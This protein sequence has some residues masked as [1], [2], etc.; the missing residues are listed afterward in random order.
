MIDPL[1]GTVLHTVQAQTEREWEIIPD[2]PEFQFEVPDLRAIAEMFGE[3]GMKPRFADLHD[4]P[5]AIHTDSCDSRRAR[6][7]A[8][9]ASSLSA[10]AKYW[11]LRMR[12]PD[13]DTRGLRRNPGGEI[14]DPLARKKF[15]AMVDSFYRSPSL[16]SLSAGELDTVISVMGEEQKVSD[17][18]GLH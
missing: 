11:A 14:K 7:A 6:L 9:Q 5:S 4:I 3:E 12:D 8:M 15:Y 17:E 18:C 10:K 13:F 16:P 2:W 1:T